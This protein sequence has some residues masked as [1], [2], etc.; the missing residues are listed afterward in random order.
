MRRSRPDEPHHVRGAGDAISLSLPSGS[1]ATTSTMCVGATAPVLRFF[2]RNRGS[3]ALHGQVEEMYTDVSGKARAVSVATLAGS[4]AWQA[5]RGGWA[6]SSPC[7]L[8]RAHEC[9]GQPAPLT[10]PALPAE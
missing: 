7:R 8:V 1:S 2:V 5:P 9:V 4:A 10:S 3:L 6:R